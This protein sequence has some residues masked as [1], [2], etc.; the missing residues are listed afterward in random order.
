MDILAHKLYRF[1][2]CILFSDIKCRCLL[3][4]VLVDLLNPNILSHDL[5]FDDPKAQNLYILG[6]L[7]SLV[8]L[9]QIFLGH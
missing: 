6:I 9:M 4:F 5:N 1:G 2:I 8:S 3:Q 7:G